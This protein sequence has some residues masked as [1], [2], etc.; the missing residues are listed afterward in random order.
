MTFYFT[1]FNFDIA[2]FEKIAQL[3]W[4]GSPNFQLN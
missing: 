2:D 4:I 1:M 3:S